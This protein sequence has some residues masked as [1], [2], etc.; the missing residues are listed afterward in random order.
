MSELR[1]RALLPRARLRGRDPGTGPSAVLPARGPRGRRGAAP[2]SG[3]SPSTGRES[4]TPLRWSLPLAERRHLLIA[5]DLAALNGSLVLTLAARSGDAMTIP[6]V[7]HFYWFIVLTALWLPLAG[8]FDVYDLRSVGRPAGWGL[9]V[10][11]AGLAVSVVYLLIP[12]V[13]PPLPG[14]RAGLAMF[15]AL[16]ILTTVGGRALFS[17]VMT[18]P[19]FRRRTIIVG[20]RRAGHTIAEAVF[21]YGGHAFQLLGIVEDGVRARVTPPARLPVASDRGTSRGEDRTLPL[22]GHWSAL[23]DLVRAY[24]AAVLVLAVTEDIEGEL[25]QTLTD[26]LEQG[27]EII[28]MPV[29]YE[30]LT[31]CVPVQD[32]GHSWSVAMPL[33]HPGTKG[34]YPLVKRGMDVGVALLGLVLLGTLLPFVALAVSVDSPGPVFYS[35][36]RVGRGGRV[37]RAHKFR[38]MVPDAEHGG[39]LWAEQNDR[40]VTRVGRVLRRTHIDELPQLWNVLVGEMSAVGPRPERPEFVETLSKVIPF[41]RVRHAVR[42]G[43]AGWGLVRQGYAASAEDALLKLQYDLY[44]IKH[45]SLWLDLVILLKTV[46]DTVTLRGR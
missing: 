20:S 1:K 38:S 36:R 19:V 12:Y 21:E 6:L 4:R 33:D 25:L 15:P 46:F 17:A 40:R 35:Q 22:L 5:L 43:M 32:I 27:V 45:Q 39:V 26:C 10:A 3:D 8:A 11:R 16:V 24:R 9:N 29:L 18:Q 13:T 42:P 2:P 34:L 30:Q 7:P 37:F 23:P 31:G 44:Y 41:Y 28:P 14:S